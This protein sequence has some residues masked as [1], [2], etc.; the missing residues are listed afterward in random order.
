MSPEQWL[1][2]NNLFHAAVE[3][4]PAQRGAFLDDSCHEDPMLRREVESLLESDR[5]DWAFIETAALEVAA[6]LF[7][8]DKPQLATDQ[9]IGHYQI[10][11]L[12]GRGGMGEVY[13]ATDERLGRPVALKLLPID[14]TINEDR[15]RRFKQEAHA[16]S[17]L[18]HPNILTIYELGEVEGQQFIAA[19]FVDGETLRELISREQI[20][21]GETLDISIQIASALAAAHKAG[22]VHRDIKPENIMVR[23]DGY[24]KVLD[25]GLA[26]LTEHDEFLTED[27]AAGSASLSSGLLMGTVKYMSPEQAEGRMTDPRSDIFSFGIVLYEMFTGCPPFEGET[28]GELIA[29]IT[30]NE[31]PPLARVSDKISVV[32]S[33]MLR[34]KKEE[35]YETIQDLLADLKIISENIAGTTEG[36]S[37]AQ[38]TDYQRFSGSGAASVST[39]SSIES[40]ISG[41]KRHKAGALFVI[42]ALILIGVGV[43]LGLGRFI[44]GRASRSQ[45]A[46]TRIPNTDK[47]EAMAISPDGRY[48]AEVVAAAVGYQILLV[49]AASG[50]GVKPLA[51]AA[52][53]RPSG[54]AFSKDGERLF[55]D[56]DRSLHQVSISDGVVTTL[57]DLNCTR[58]AVS[59]DEKLVACV[60]QDDS[61]VV[62]IVMRLDGTDARLIATRAKPGFLDQPTW[63]PGGDVIACSFGLT[64][65]VQTQGLTAFEVANG[66]EI[67]ITPLRWQSIGRLLW[68]S[69]GRALIASAQETAGEPHQIW[70]ISYSDG[71]VRRITSDLENYESPSLTADGHGLAA[72]DSDAR[73]SIWTMSNGDF[74]TATPITNGEH[75]IYRHV[76]WL[77]DGRILYAS[78]IGKSRDIWIM[79]GDGT[80]PNQLTRD[81]GVN[82]QPQPCGNGRYVVYSSDRANSG[83]FDIWRMDSDGND[84][85]QV[86]FGRQ[87]VQPVC[88]PNGRWIVY[89]KGGPASTPDKKTLWKVP[90]DSG[91]PIQLCDHAASG[92]TFSP[93]GTSIACWYKPDDATPMKMAILPFSGGPAIHIFDIPMTAIH[94]VRWSPDGLSLDYVKAEPFV[95]NVWSQPVTGGTP[96]R[97]TQFT[98][99][100]LEGFDVSTDG[101][102]VCSRLHGVQDVVMI[103]NF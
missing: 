37:I 62:L 96:K 60:R 78:N 8:D 100:L 30:K 9:T 64:A 53:D 94:P 4:E 27:P 20:S 47:A 74:D 7:A 24:V 59:P 55:Y 12:L 50:N 82:L 39:Q 89:S 25:F 5:T 41:V 32:V 57:A 69:S 73:S 66:N 75:H 21:V 17:A 97:I 56:D 40:I 36:R 87:A 86:T 83:T 99:E 48:I 84:Q 91:E 42:S 11:K 90:F 29:A 70:Q 3:L 45:M 6:P 79:N 95:G 34:K 98:S 13:L 52:I 44:V 61:G 65:P 81:A 67:P 38:N 1:Q 10:I 80:N 18:N 103:R 16:A 54:L 49:D 72:I 15:L 19:E 71:D 77:P 35:R 43:L 23:P 26:K 31:P 33:R 102:L 51:S 2:V 85:T 101:R 14:Y 22:I 68:L 93:D 28:S 63:S 92:P 46:I 76:S 88:S 58:P